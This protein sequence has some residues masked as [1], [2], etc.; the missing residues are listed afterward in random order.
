MRKLFLYTV[1]AIMVFS[2]TKDDGETA[3]KDSFIRLYGNAYLDEGL[4]LRQL[5]DNSYL[6]CASYSNE[7]EV[8]GGKVFKLSQNGQVLW[9]YASLDT[10]DLTIKSFFV[11]TDNT[12]V[13]VGHGINPATA[14]YDIVL[15][16]LTSGGQLEWKKYAGGAGNQYGNALCQAVDGGY[17]VGGSTDVDGDKDV[18]LHK[19]SVEGDSL[20]VRKYGTDSEDEIKDICRSHNGGFL[21]TGNYGFAAGGQTGTNLAAIEINQFGNLVDTYTYEGVGN[22]EGSEVAMTDDGYIFVGTTQSAGNGETDIFV[23][24][25][26]VSIRDVQWQ[27][28]YGGNAAEI[29]NSVFVNDDGTYTI[30][31]ST[32]SYGEGNRDAYVLNLSSEG[33][34]VIEKTFGSSGNEWVNSAIQAAD[35]GFGL[36]GATEFT[37]NRMISFIKLN[38][39]YE[40]E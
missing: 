1:I 17:I 8:Q 25:T 28:T 33:T 5:E 11:N 14:N 15:G 26:S 29:G 23:V 30:A 13:W 37:E 27:K 24:K 2:C 21:L 35:G 6:A 34:M 31:G 4:Y 9:E 16:K 20:W 7:D 40:L 38:G 12:V 19:F 39:N 3:K 22:D 32:E 36:L 10:L 18:Y